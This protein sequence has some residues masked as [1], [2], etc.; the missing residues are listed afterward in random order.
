MKDY[1]FAVFSIPFLY[2]SLNETKTMNRW[3][4]SRRKKEFATVC[5]FALN[6]QNIRPFH[7][8]VKLTVDL[9]F[10][11]KRRR[12]LDNY[13]IKFLADALVECG[14]IPDDSTDWMPESADIQIFSGEPEEKVD[15]RIERI[16][17]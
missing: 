15:V 17:T 7:C 12:D 10:K 6:E 1:S 5:A 13:T 4:Y 14:I 2:P 3:E 16:K 9:C 8:P 11:K